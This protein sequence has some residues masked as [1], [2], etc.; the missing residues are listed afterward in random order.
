MLVIGT[1]AIASQSVGP[2]PVGGHQFEER[3]HN[4][5]ETPESPSAKR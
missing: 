4:D 2:A 5:H 1:A 3:A